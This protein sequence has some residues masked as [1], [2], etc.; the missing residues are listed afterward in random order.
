MSLKRNLPHYC[1]GVR[2][3]FSFPIDGSPPTMR[4]E[5]MTPEEIKK[6]NEKF[7]VPARP[8]KRNEKI[9]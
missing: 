1:I 6:V 3:I 7:S 4:V 2:T 9:K 5:E 8:D